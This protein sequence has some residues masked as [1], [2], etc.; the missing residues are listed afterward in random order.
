[1]TDALRPDASSPIGKTA[2]IKANG[3]AIELG[4]DGMALLLEAIRRC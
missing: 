4:A 2:V 3:V 1:M